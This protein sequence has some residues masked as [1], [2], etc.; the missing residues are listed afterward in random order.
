MLVEG[1]RRV[2]TALRPDRWLVLPIQSTTDDVEPFVAAVVAH[3]AHLLGGG[4]IT[5]TEARALLDDAGFVDVTELLR[6]DQVL[7]VGRRP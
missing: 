6:G 3:S 7:L 1:L 2:R 5:V 4:P